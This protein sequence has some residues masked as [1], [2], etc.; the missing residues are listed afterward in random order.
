MLDLII[1]NSTTI[2]INEALIYPQED[3]EKHPTKNVS[4]MGSKYKPKNNKDIHCIWEF[5]QRTNKKWKIENAQR[6]CS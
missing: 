3:Q 1:K 6:G 4:Q 2:T 5:Q